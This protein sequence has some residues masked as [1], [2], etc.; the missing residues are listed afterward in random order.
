MAADDTMEKQRANE[1]RRT[2]SRD[3]TDPVT[4]RFR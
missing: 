4:S 2:E 3:R 1:K